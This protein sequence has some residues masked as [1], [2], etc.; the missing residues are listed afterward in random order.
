MRETV[1]LPIESW[2]FSFTLIICLI[3]IIP[4]VSTR[5]LFSLIL[6]TSTLYHTEHLLRFSFFLFLFLFFI[7]FIPYI[8][9]RPSRRSHE[10]WSDERKMQL[11]FMFSENKKESETRTRQNMTFKFVSLT[12]FFSP[13]TARRLLTIWLFQSRLIQEQKQKKRNNTLEDLRRLKFSSRNCVCHYFHVAIDERKT[14]S[15]LTSLAKKNDIV[16]VS[17]SIFRA[18]CVITTNIHVPCQC[19]TISIE[20]H[21]FELLFRFFS[22]Y[23]LEKSSRSQSIQMNMFL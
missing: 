10:K 9:V 13:E 7:I 20:C 23:W 14:L 16:S 4:I 17:K 3:S 22:F 1:L 12:F 5:Q 21:Q 15:V 2:T 18:L 19:H 11:F 8:A 6:L